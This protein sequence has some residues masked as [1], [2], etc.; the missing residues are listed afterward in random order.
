MGHMSHDHLTNPS[1]NTGKGNTS[2]FRKPATPYKA[3][4]PSNKGS[5]AAQKVHAIMA[6]LDNKDL[7]EAKTAFIECLDDDAESVEEENQDF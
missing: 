4:M 6:E 5:N 1:L 7:E 3:T 2:N